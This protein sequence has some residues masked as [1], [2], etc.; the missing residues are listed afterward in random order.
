MYWNKLHTMEN[1]TTM[2]AYPNETGIVK[3]DG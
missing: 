3:Y 1:T 2:P